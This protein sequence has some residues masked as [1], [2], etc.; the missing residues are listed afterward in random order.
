MH[1]C[2]RRNGG[3]SSAA[4]TRGSHTHTP[5]ADAPTCGGN[6]EA[7]VTESSHATAPHHRPAFGYQLWT[8][9]GG[10]Y[11]CARGEPQT[12]A[13]V[14]PAGGVGVLSC[15]NCTVVKVVRHNWSAVCPFSHV[16]CRRCG[17][18]PLKHTHTNTCQSAHVKVGTT[19]QTC[20]Q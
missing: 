3:D 9:F 1:E 17:Q 18:Q 10:L 6:V 2:V 15:C 7:P 20:T 14:R 4:A 8:S 11:A 19:R 12:N 13:I 16:L 5:A